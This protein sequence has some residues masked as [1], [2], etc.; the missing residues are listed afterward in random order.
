[1]KCTTTTVECASYCTN[2]KPQGQLTKPLQRNHILLAALALL[3]TPRV[4]QVWGTAMRVGA[5]QQAEDGREGGCLGA[6]KLRWDA[7]ST[8]LTVH[9]LQGD[10]VAGGWV[11][12][13]SWLIPRV[14]QSPSLSL[15]YTRDG[16]GRYG[17]HSQNTELAVYSSTAYL[18]LT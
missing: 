9:N 1:M 3:W 15:R 11:A 18:H 6:T 2:N 7:T 4:L 16:K 5:T 13:T 10:R 14:A 8:A 12:S 17:R